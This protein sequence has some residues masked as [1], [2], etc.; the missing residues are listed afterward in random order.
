MALNLKPFL[1]LDHPDVGH[2][3]IELITRP[4]GTKSHS[5]LE[6]EKPVESNS[7]F[8][9]PFQ[10]NKLKKSKEIL[11]KLKI[12]WKVCLDQYKFLTRIVI[13]YSYKSL[14]FYL[15]SHFLKIILEL[16]C[17]TMQYSTLILIGNTNLFKIN[18]K[19]ID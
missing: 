6:K 15:Y 3:N 13:L 2:H 11:A 7:Y 16:L 18:I 14:H 1:P 17:S 10:K 4:P 9:T 12:I 5:P 8:K 19:Y